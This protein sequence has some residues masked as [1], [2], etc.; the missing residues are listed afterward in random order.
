M[1]NSCGPALS[2]G[3]MGVTSTRELTG[4]Q[5]PLVTVPAGEVGE[6]WL[7]AK[8]THLPRLTMAAQ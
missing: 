6:D 7:H 1:L 8:G 4:K 3:E 2:Q 5:L